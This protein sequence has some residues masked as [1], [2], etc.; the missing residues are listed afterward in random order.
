[1]V[2]GSARPMEDAAR[3]AYAELVRWLE[4]EYDFHRWDAYDLLSQAGGLYVGNMVDTNYSLVASIKKIIS[5][6]SRNWKAN[7]G[8][9]ILLTVP[10]MNTISSE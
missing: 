8:A 7:G 9:A 1:M 5:S 4:E 3:I 6:A 10:I 2:V